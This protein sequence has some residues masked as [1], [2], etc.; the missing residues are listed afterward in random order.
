[1]LITAVITLAGVIAWAVTARALFRRWARKT[2]LAYWF[3][4]TL[5][6]LAALALPVILPVLAFAAF[7]MH[8]PPL[9]QHDLKVKTQALEAE[10]ARLRR[11]QGG[12]REHLG[13]LGHNYDE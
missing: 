4:A 7:V 13:S 5:A 9:S 1:M 11:E 8:D 10:N 12:P 3:A 2:Q 6:T